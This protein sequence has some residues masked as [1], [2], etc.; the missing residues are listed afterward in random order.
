[1]FAKRK[2]GDIELKESKEKIHLTNFGWELQNNAI[3]N[4]IDT[5]CFRFIS[6]HFLDNLSIFL[7]GA[8][9]F[10]VEVWSEKS[11]FLGG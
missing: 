1:M 10:F 11:L 9:F 6:P 2:I 5:I 8:D 3:K 7:S 4:W